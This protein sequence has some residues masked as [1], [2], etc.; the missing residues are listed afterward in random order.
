M[1]KMVTSRLQWFLE[2]NNLLS[3][4]QTGFRKN[5]STTHH[6]LRLQDYI[7]KKLKNK[8]SVLAVFIDFERA[9]DM[10]HVPTL[11]QKLQN[12]GITGHT[13]NWI[14]SF[15]SNRTFQVKVGAELSDKYSQENGTPQ[16]SI[17]S[18]VLFLL[19]INDIPPGLGGVDMTLF[20]D[21]SAIYVGHR[22]IK[23][24]EQRIQSS[25]NE[26][27]EWCDKNGFKISINKTTAVLFSY[28]RSTPKINLKIGKKPIKLEKTAKFLGVIFDNKLTWNAH[29]K[30]IV[31]K[32]KRRINVTREEY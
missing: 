16:G 4:N 14:E 5:K 26:I 19:M 6:I 3:K 22:N 11:L 31:E 20:A 17:I 29:I 7:L 25:L 23:T 8:E 12:I 18:P 27:H 32:C 1:E 15:L 9:Y 13:L 30:Y 2:K 21:D 28:A 24:S 10:L